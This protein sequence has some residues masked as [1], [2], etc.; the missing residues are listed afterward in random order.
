M[1]TKSAAWYRLLFGPKYVAKQVHRADLANLPDIRHI[2]DFRLLPNQRIAVADAALSP[3]TRLRAGDEGHVES[4]LAPFTGFQDVAHALARET[5]PAESQHASV[6]SVGA[7]V[8]VVEGGL[9]CSG[10]TV[11]DVLQ[12]LCAELSKRL[13]PPS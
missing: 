11:P 13:W 10:P 9:L 2:L 6:D 1:F 8:V 12:R 4:V 3:F 7:P 5:Q